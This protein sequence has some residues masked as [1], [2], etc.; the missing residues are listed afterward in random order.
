MSNN[1]LKRFRNQAALHD[2]ILVA[3]YSISIVLIATNFCFLLIQ[4]IESEP[5]EN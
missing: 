3:T 1:S 2:I 5:K 4:D